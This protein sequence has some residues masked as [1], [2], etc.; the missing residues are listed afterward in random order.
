MNWTQ[1]IITLISTL[2]GGGIMKLVL[3][4]ETKASA[5]LDNAERVIAKYEDLLSRN[6]KEIRKLQS[7]VDELTSYCEQRDHKIGELEK[8]IVALKYDIDSQKSR[9]GADGRFVK[10]GTVD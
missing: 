2:I 8:R 1:I 6:E 3:L 7:K 9:R 5:K 4:P 10:H